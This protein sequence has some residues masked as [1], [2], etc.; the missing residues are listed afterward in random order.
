MVVVGK[1][2]LSAN[3]SIASLH[4]RQQADHTLDCFIENLAI[5]AS[6]NSAEGPQPWVSPLPS[7]RGHV[8]YMV[9]TRPDSGTT[10]TN[11]PCMP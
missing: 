2:R 1:L 5:I 11:W 7:A 10:R 6:I 9:M 4:L 8:E 3:K